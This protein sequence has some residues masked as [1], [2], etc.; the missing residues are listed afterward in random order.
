MTVVL[1]AC[2]LG[3]EKESSELKT[4]KPNTNSLPV[5]ILDRIS[6]NVDQFDC[7]TLIFISCF[8]SSI[9]NSVCSQ[10]ENI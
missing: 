4:N 9:T 5:K 10:N 2:S 1:L 3:K 8:T 7:Q 6:Y